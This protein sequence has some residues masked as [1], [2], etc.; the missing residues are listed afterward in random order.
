[1]FLIAIHHRKPVSRINIS[2]SIFVADLRL[3]TKEDTELGKIKGR[4]RIS[5]M[6]EVAVD[7]HAL[8]ERQQSEVLL[9]FI[10]L[11]LTISEW[12]KLADSHPSNMDA[13]FHGP[14]PLDW[15]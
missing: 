10:S 13:V 7:R 9:T 12:Q 15:W 2:I 1:M 11:M 5:A 8:R 6:A 3:Q 14:C 4:D